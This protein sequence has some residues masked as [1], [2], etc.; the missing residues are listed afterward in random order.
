[1]SA[2]VQLLSVEDAL[3]YIMSEPAAPILTADNLHPDFFDLR[4]DM[5]GEMFQKF[6]NYRFQVAIV[7]P[8]DHDYGE[9]IDELMRD[10]RSHPWI[11]FFPTVELAQSWLAA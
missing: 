11:R 8:E 3:G 6:V 2:D 9:R 5:L 7:V 4:N 10:H 1:M